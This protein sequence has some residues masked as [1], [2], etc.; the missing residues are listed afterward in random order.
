MPEK[1][2]SIDHINI[3]RSPGRNKLNRFSNAHKPMQLA[4]RL[5]VFTRSMER[6]GV[7]PFPDLFKMLL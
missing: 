1:V 6:F 3:Q 7:D 5:E 4:N 2:F